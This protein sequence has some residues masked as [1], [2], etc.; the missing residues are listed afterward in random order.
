MR[1]SE[2]PGF[3]P[4][5]CTLFRRI[6]LGCCLLVSAA[7][8]LIS[9]P[10]SIGIEPFA[11]PPDDSVLAE[12]ARTIADTLELSFLLLDD[13]VFTDQPAVVIDGTTKRDGRGVGVAVRATSTETG[14]TLCEIDDQTD[15]ILDTFDLVDRVELSLLETLS[16]YE[17]RFGSL[18]M[19]VLSLQ[20]V[21]SILID[22]HT[23]P[24]DQRYLARVPTGSHTVTV[25]VGA[26]AHPVSIRRTVEITP[27]RESEVNLVFPSVTTELREAITRMYADIVETESPSDRETIALENDLRSAA[28]ELGDHPAGDSF[29]TWYSAGRSA[30]SLWSRGRRNDIPRFV[31]EVDGDPGEWMGLPTNGGPWIDLRTSVNEPGSRLMSFRLAVSPDGRTISFLFESMDTISFTYDYRIYFRPDR[32]ATDGIDYV[33]LNLQPIRQGANGN[34][35]VNWYTGDWNRVEPAPFRTGVRYTVNSPYIEGTMTLENTDISVLQMVDHVKAE[36]RTIE[37]RQNIYRVDGSLRMVHA[38]DSDEAGGERVAVPRPAAERAPAIHPEDIAAWLARIEH[39]RESN[40][41]LP[42]D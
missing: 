33:Q 26:A 9:E 12:V 24:P 6:T 32:A 27:G 15:S 22:R 14:E 37:G 2:S 29:S 40:V 10:T 13:F 30:R 42:V 5:G 41:I 4:P 35:V 28:T 20:P 25:T 1:T 18:S 21:M 3:L 16:G 34:G 19:N 36:R 39:T 11:A 17:V 23:I 31:A 7:A 38:R 8:Q